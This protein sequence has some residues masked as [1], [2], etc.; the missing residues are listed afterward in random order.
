MSVD[1]ELRDRMIG[2]TLR[3]VMFDGW[4]RAVLEIA[5]RDLRLG[6]G[7]AMRAFPAGPA[8]A[9]E[10]FATM[11]DRAMLEALERHD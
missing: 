8:D 6:A 2:A 3:H 1:G 10:H 5:A 11:A 7:A 4:S 9:I